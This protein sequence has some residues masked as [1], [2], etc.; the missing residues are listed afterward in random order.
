MRSSVSPEVDTVFSSGAERARQ[1]SSVKSKK[2]PLRK[3]PQ[4]EFG[5]KSKATRLNSGQIGLSGSSIHA[6]T[7]VG[8]IARLGKWGLSVPALILTMS[9]NLSLA[10]C[11]ASRSVGNVSV[12]R[13]KD[14]FPSRGNSNETYQTPFELFAMR[15]KPSRHYSLGRSELLAVRWTF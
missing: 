8:A 1:W 11:F 7:C 13:A 9:S 4:G 5:C 10:N 15:P 12:D 3:K 2:R 14:R 6:A